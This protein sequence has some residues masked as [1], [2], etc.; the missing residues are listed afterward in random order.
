MRFV[1]DTGGPDATTSRTA[2]AGPQDQRFREPPLKIS[3]DADRYDHARG[4]TTIRR[5]ETCSA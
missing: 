5:P 1:A 2:S 3:G 4:T